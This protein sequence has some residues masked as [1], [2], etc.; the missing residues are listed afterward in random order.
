M[1]PD[2]DFFFGFSK[3]SALIEVVVA[4]VSSFALMSLSTPAIFAFSTQPTV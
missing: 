2:S 3:I 1:P 4:P